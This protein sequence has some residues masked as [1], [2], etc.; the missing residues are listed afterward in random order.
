MEMTE[1]PGVALDP[2]GAETRVIH[3]L[4][5]FTGKDVLEIGCGE[6]RLTRRFASR[7]RSVLAVDLD[8]ESIA[9]ASAQLPES[10][11]SAVRFQVADIAALELPSETFDV[12]I[13]S[14][15]L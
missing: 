13:L 4:I 1:K 11:R 14:W 15:S 3:D 5:D 10:L 12:A 9:L 2:E 6:G 7:A 8:T